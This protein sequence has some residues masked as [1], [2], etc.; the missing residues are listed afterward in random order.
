MI[1][2]IMIVQRLG[3]GERE[4]CFG[5]DFHGSDTNKQLMSTFKSKR[6]SPI[7]P[8]RYFLVKSFVNADKIRYM[9]AIQS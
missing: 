3:T 9:K 2:R 6:Y 1:H 8:A 4:G 5:L 7:R